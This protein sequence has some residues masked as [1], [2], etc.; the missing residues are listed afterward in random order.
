[1]EL[2]ILAAGL[3]KRLDSHSKEPKAL[4]VLANGQSILAFQLEMLSRYIESAKISIVVGYHFESVIK[5][6]PDLRYIYNENFAE[7]NT[8]GSL[9]KAL[10]N[11]DDDLLFLNG[12][13]VFH[14][15]VIKKLLN[16]RQT[17]MLVIKGIVAEE[18]VKYRCDN[19]DQIVEVSKELRQSEGE[20]IGIN[21]FAKEDLPKLKLQLERCSPTEYF[22]KAIENGIKEGLKVKA[23]PIEATLAC[24]VDFPED[25]QKA[26][27]LLLSWKLA[28]YSLF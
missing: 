6:F 28:G 1:M 9:K 11:L 5:L 7:D 14:P 22:E 25:L 15:S 20:A 10:K 3:G 2:V 23:L 27:Q 17:A 21:Y 18:E 26:N 8:A 24:E 12:D 13:V 16:F 4:T 19:L